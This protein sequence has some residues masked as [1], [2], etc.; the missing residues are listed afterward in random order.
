MCPF[1]VRPTALLCGDADVFYAC[2]DVIMS[3]LSYLQETL[4]CTLIYTHLSHHNGQ[5][6]YYSYFI[7]MP[8]LCMKS[9]KK[10]SCK[11]ILLEGKD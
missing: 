5:A 9:S 7:S 10:K 3:G 11:I 1:P 8:C 2:M 6:N 4:N